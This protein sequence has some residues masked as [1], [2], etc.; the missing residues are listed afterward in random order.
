MMIPI[1]LQKDHEAFLIIIIL[2]SIMRIGE[3]IIL[4]YSQKSR[5]PNDAKY[6]PIIDV[7]FVAKNMS[8]QS[9]MS[10]RLAR[11]F[12]SSTVKNV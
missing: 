3:K 8:S 9:M 10:I 2:P 11:I 7:S 5:F 1:N 12:W 4:K 6:P